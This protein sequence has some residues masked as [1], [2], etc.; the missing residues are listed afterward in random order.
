MKKKKNYAKKIRNK[1][2]RNRRIAPLKASFMIV[3]IIGFFVSA[4]W[5]YGLTPSYAT[6][7]AFLFFCMFIASLISM[8][9]APTEDYDFRKG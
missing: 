3:S 6:A 5:L 2:S 1:V 9:Y 4:F 8:T 7:F